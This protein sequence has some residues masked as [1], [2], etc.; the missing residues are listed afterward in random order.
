MDAI[1]LSFNATVYNNPNSST[2]PLL[3]CGAMAGTIDPG[4][5]AE[6]LFIAS[7]Q[8]RVRSEHREIDRYGPQRPCLRG[9]GVR[10]FVKEAGLRH[11]SQARVM[12]NVPKVG[13]ARLCVFPVDFKAALSPAQAASAYLFLN[14]GDRLGPAA[15]TAFDREPKKLREAL[16]RSLP[17]TAD[18]S[19]SNTDA[20]ANAV[21]HSLSTE[22]APQRSTQDA[23]PLAQMK[24]AWHK[25]LAG[26][27]GQ[28]PFRRHLVHLGRLAAAIPPH[29]ADGGKRPATSMHMAFVGPPGTGKTEAGRRLGRILHGYGLLTKPETSMVSARELVG[30]HIGHT[31]PRVRRVVKEALGGVLFIDEAYALTA[32]GSKRDFGPEVIATLIELMETHRHELAVV[33]AGYEEPMQRFLDSNPGLRSRVPTVVEFGRLTSQ[34]A[35]KVFAGFAKRDGVVIGPNVRPLWAR[36]ACFAQMP[37]TGRGV[38]DLY[39]RILCER[40]VRRHALEGGRWHLRAEDLAG[41]DWNLAD[42]VIGPISAVD[43]S[44]LPGRPS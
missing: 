29:V 13:P 19:S 37:D 7:R 1:K 14:T 12:A 20:A 3:Y 17:M 8:T 44:G 28:R 22:A 25:G 31:S 43:L 30:T 4:H 41:V 33:F 9:R 42:G 35:W 24:A 27:V 23:P 6:V 32:S 36:M 18:E 39:E 10:A 34:Q 15:A 38:R 40:I 2:P 26:Y 5:T 21:D 11:G 16:I